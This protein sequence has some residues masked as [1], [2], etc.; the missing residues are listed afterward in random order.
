MSSSNQLAHTPDSAP[1][2]K[3]CGQC[4][5]PYDTDGIFCTQCGAP[6]AK[7]KGDLA[8]HGGSTATPTT[9]TTRPYPATPANLDVTSPLLP[10]TH[11]AAAAAAAV[12]Q[13]NHAAANEGRLVQT[14]RRRMERVVGEGLGLAIEDPTK[15]N[16][17]CRVVKVW[18]DTVASRAGV[19]TGD[20]IVAFQG[21]G[22]VGDA[23]AL[24]FNFQQIT[25][26]LEKLGP[27]FDLI[28]SPDATPFEAATPNQPVVRIAFEDATVQAM[29]PIRTC[30]RRIQ[31]A[32]SNRLSNGN[33][34]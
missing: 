7:L 20:V 9:P 4:G 32:G 28:V 34:Q 22:G 17:G 26:A 13:T 3:F 16:I 15:G 2:A 29:V 19:R 6:Y 14:Y 5:H 12:V 21:V 31:R 1:R 8:I 25:N 18:D 23:F 33:G 24:K 30:R 27:L 10:A 11:S